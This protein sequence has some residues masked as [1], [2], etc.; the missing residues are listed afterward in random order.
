LCDPQAVNFY[1]A[2]AVSTLFTRYQTSRTPGGAPDTTKDRPFWGLAPGLAAPGDP[3]YPVANG[4]DLTLF[5]ADPAPPA[6]SPAG[7]RLFEPNPTEY[8]NDTAGQSLSGH[9]YAR[10]ELLNKI[11]NNVTTRS[12]VF[13]VYTTVG[14]FDYTGGKLGAEIGA[15]EGRAVRHRSFTIVDRSALTVTTNQAATPQLVR[16]FFLESSAAVTKGSSQ[17][18]LPA[19]SGVYDGTPWSIVAGATLFVDFGSSQETMTVSS[20]AGNTVTFTTAFAN[21]HPAGAAVANAQLGNPGPQPRF[22]PRNPAY[23]P[24]VRYFSIIR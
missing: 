9:P 2:G 10:F 23:G 13:A 3:Q 21:A 8:N 7:K 24:V 11:F 17:M 5:R 1:N 22:D 14:Y 12:N 18:T 4:L 6:A 16:P 20:V 19:I 15:T